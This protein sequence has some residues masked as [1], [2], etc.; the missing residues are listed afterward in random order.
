MINAYAK[1]LKAGIESGIFRDFNVA[2]MAEQVFQLTE[3]AIVALE[4]G[5]LGSP[6]E[7]AA[8]TAEF[9]MRS[10]LLKPARLSGGGQTIA[11]RRMFRV[12]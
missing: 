9:V 8:S 7:Q 3:T 1:Q 5:K 4:P 12:K 2:L 6:N 10:L 11:A